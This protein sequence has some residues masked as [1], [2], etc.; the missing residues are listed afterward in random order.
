[1]KHKM[2]SIWDEVLETHSSIIMAIN[3]GHILRMIEGW[4]KQQSHPLV[5]NPKDKTLFELGEFDDTT[6]R[7]EQY[8]TKKLVGML[9]EFKFDEQQLQQEMSN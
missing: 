5:T 7:I 6:G 9:H 1:M 3:K 4:N 8:D 2:Y